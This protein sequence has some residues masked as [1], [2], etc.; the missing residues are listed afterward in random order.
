M[1][2]KTAHNGMDTFGAEEPLPPYTFPLYVVNHSPS[3]IVVT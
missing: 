3:K 2:K 1:V